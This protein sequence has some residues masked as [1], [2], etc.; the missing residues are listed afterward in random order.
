MKLRACSANSLRKRSFDI[1]VHVFEGTV[2][3]EFARLDFFFDSTQLAFNFLQF[4]NGNDSCSS[5]RC[6]VRDRSSDIEA[7]QLPIKEN[8]FAVALRNLC[9]R[10]FESS[11][12]HR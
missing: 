2:P 11:F 10:F 5:E 7:I 4:I 12:P 3:L 9:S 6:G 8:R 1:H